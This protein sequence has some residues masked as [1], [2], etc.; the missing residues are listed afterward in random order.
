[1]FEASLLVQDIFT[2]DLEPRMAREP[3][4]PL[5]VNCQNLNLNISSLEISSVA[6]CCAFSRCSNHTY[7]RNSNDI[8]CCI[9]IIDPANRLQ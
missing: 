7:S 3:A 8:F 5:V 2:T 9:E 4:I 6:M 1:M